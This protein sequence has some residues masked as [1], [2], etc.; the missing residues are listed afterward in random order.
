MDTCDDDLLSRAL[1]YKASPS[2]DTVEF[3]I[4]P[5]VGTEHAADAEGLRALQLRCADFIR[6]RIASYLWHCG[7]PVL[8]VDMQ[9]LGGTDDGSGGVDGSGGESVGCV[10][11]SL[12]FGDSAADEWYLLA[13]LASLSA[14]VPRASVAA[15]DGDG[16]VLLI[17]AAEA[18]PHWLSPQNSANRVFLRGGRLHAV[19]PSGPRPYRGLNLWAGLAAARAPEA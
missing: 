3:L 17:E 2:D 14:A 12:R 11:G 5:D 19:P 13:V 15:R 4:Y 6:P 9:M 10:R 16:E 8:R 1:N 7:A 18:L